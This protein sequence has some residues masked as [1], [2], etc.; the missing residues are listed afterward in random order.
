MTFHPTAGDLE[1]AKE[2]CPRSEHDTLS[3]TRQWNATHH[4][5]GDNAYCPSD[6]FNVQAGS[7]CQNPLY[8]DS[9]NCA[10]Q[11]MR[12]VSS[13]PPTSAGRYLDE[14]RASR[15]TRSADGDKKL[16]SLWDSLGIN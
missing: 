12:G 15:A 9:A 13:A 2:A 3:K 7:P 14:V 8:A 4:K 10:M 6:I 16:H 5:L 1:R 11:R